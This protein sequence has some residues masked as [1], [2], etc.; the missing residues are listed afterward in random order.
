MTLDQ[1][2]FAE[3]FI[4][5]FK[6]FCIINH[7]KNYLFGLEGFQGSLKLFGNWFLKRLEIGMLYDESPTEMIHLELKQFSNISSI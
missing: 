3:I 1:Q 2:F 7:V 4:I 6:D 5:F